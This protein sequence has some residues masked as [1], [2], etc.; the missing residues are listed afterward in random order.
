MKFSFPPHFH[1]DQ[2]PA[3]WQ[4]PYE[5][6]MTVKFLESINAKSMLEIG[7]GY[8]EMA[9]YLRNIKNMNVKS[10]DKAPMGDIHAPKDLFIGDSTTPRAF[11][12][13]FENASY[14][15]YDVVYI[16]GGHD[17]KTCYHDYSTYSKLTKK[18][19]IIHDIDGNQ[20]GKYP[21]E[22]GPWA[23]WNQARFEYRTLE[24]H[25]KSPGNCGIG[26]CII[27]GV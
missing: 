4:N 5:F 16:D 13:A 1:Y 6:R 11:E 2:E 10:I 22:G 23:V 14:G 3:M 9:K 7:T 8:G 27:G 18:V 12:W 21:V 26:I 20:I 17:Y 15:G 24:I 19:M 25:A